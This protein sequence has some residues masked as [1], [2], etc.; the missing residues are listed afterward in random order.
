MFQSGCKQGIV[1][2][3]IAYC[4]LAVEAIYQGADSLWFIA[5]FYA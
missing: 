4:H 5:F 2:C 3:H 1:R